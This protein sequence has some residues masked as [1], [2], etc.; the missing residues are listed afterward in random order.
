VCVAGAVAK[1]RT[2]AAAA[3]LFMGCNSLVR[4]HLLML[5]ILLLLF[6]LLI[7]RSHLVPPPLLSKSLGPNAVAAATWL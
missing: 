1:K 2:L 7:C 5:P 4:P 3:E 6:L